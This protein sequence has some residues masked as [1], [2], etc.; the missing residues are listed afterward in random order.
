MQEGSPAKISLAQLF[1][2]VHQGGIS[3]LYPLE[4]NTFA[5]KKLPKHSSELDSPFQQALTTILNSYEDIFTLPKG[6]PPTRDSDHQIP[7]LVDTKPVNVWP[8]KYLHFHK[9]EIERLV[10]E[11]F[12][13][14]T[15]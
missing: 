8:Y 12:N 5:L 1:H 3:H 11:M 2:E 13:E 4:L 10:E 7:L 14:G 9:V 6:L 15:I